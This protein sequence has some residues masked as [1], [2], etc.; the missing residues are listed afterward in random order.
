MKNSIRWGI[1]GCGNF[2]QKFVSENVNFDVL[3][4]CSDG[5]LKSIGINQLGTRK[6]ILNAL[7]GY[8]PES[9]YK[10]IFQ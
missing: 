4:D 1:L 8:K 10:I 3:K 5:E 6:Q 2:A 9:K 7:K